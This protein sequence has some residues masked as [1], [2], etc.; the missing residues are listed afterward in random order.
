MNWELLTAKDFKEAIEPCGGVCLLPFGCVEK[1][2]DHL[3]LGQ[4]F[5]YTHEACTRAAAEAEVM[6]FPPYYFGFISEARH[7]PGTVALQSDLLVRLFENVC[8]EI[9][10]NGFKKIV[11]VNGHGGNRDFLHFFVKDAF[12]Q[13]NKDYMIYIAE[14]FNLAND[15]EAKKVAES[16]LDYHAGEKETSNMLY[17][18]PELVKEEFFS[19]KGLP[20]GRLKAFSEAMIHTG[21]W[22]YADFPYHLAAEK[23]P[24][25]A[26]KGKVFVEAHVRS[27]VRQ[28][29]IIRADETPMK[30]YQEYKEAALHIR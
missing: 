11:I 5:L 6:V 8:D 4:D 14:T 27:L 17:L 10:R 3:P 18:R 1:H 13:G 7:V 9:A 25:S 23:V 28:I 26:D 20:Q 12:L 30:L 21:I 29:Q 2:G 16:K 15:A 22:W 19:D 24:C